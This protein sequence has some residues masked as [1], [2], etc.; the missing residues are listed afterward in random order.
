MWTEVDNTGNHC[1][2]E[3][4]RSWSCTIVAPV[5]LLN[6]FQ[7][8]PWTTVTAGQPALALALAASIPNKLCPLVHV[9]DGSDVPVQLALY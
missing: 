2:P 9:R 4:A 5:L 6:I 1:N 7:Y 8:T 3:K